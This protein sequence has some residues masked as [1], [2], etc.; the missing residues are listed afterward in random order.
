MAQPPL[1]ASRP[2]SRQSTRLSTPLRS[3]PNYVRTDTDTRRSLRVQPATREAS[4]S[5]QPTSITKSRKRVSSASTKSAAPK[6][7]QKKSKKSTNN[8][9]T[10]SESDED[11]QFLNLPQDS[12]EDNS[13]LTKQTKKTR[14]PNK[15]DYD[16]IGLYFEAP[17]YGEGNT[18]GKKLYYQ[19]KWCNRQPY[20]TSTRTRSNLFKHCDGD[21]L[22]KPC[23]SRDEAIKNGANLPVTIKEKIEREKNASVLTNLADSNFDNRTLN[24]IL[25]MWLMQSALPWMRIED[26]LL[27]ISFNYARKGIKLYSRTWAAEEAQRLYV[28]LQEKVISNLKSL[29]SKI[30]LIHDVWTT[31]GNHHAFLGIAAAYITEDW[32]F[33]ICH[34]GLKYISW[35]HKAQTTDS[36]SNN[37]T[38]TAEVDRIITKKTGINPDLS[39]NH[40]RC[41]CHKIALIVASGL[42]VIDTNTS[43]LTKCKKKTLGHVPFLDTIPENNNTQG[44]A[45]L[46]GDE[47]LDAPVLDQS[48]ED[49]EDETD[50]LAGSPGNSET[51]AG[52]LSKVDFVIQRITSSSSKRSEFELWRTKL[53]DPGP[54]LI[55]G[56]GIRWNIKWQSQDR[57][58]QSRNVINK[59]IE[60]EKDRQERDGGKSFYQDCDITRGDWEIVKQLNDILSEF[61]FITKKMEGDHSSCGMLLVEYQSI[62][63]FLKD[64]LA[65][66]TENEFRSMLKKMI[67]K[68]ET[69]LAEAL[70]CN[71]ILLTTM[72]NPSYRLSIFQAYFSSHHK[73]AEIL[74]QQKFDERKAELAATVS[75]RESTPQQPSQPQKTSH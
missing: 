55:A 63:D 2:P 31:K 21:V 44:A 72:L 28:N 61:Y 37:R 4:V 25:V 30:T 41:V 9:E 5:S 74:L 40:I 11:V 16:D 75:S 20:K 43:G 54:N 26:T 3:H 71:T 49:C 34:L 48:D 1:P 33:E 7:S 17:Q 60:N 42:K 67:E 59:L 36:G 38:M 24:Q 53:D 8:R 50:E 70:A 47:D 45:F 66:V 10:T 58:Y 73:Y 57:A 56:Y 29:K 35:T 62:K 32:A 12:D 39:S 22:R 68:T 27:A 18:D 64:R 19:C 14:G 13:K 23:E 6:K 15:N 51:M 46:S 65:S 69:Y 52:I